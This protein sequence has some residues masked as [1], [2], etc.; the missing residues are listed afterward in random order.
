MKTKIYPYIF[1]LI[2]ATISTIIPLIF[3]E[4]SSLI[5][6]LVIFSVTGIV[7][8]FT[9]WLLLMSIKKSIE[10]VMTSI[11]KTDKDLIAYEPMNYIKS[12]FVCSL[13]GVG[14]LYKDKLVFSSHKLNFSH[15]ELVV[16]LSETQDIRSYR[17]LGI[18]NKGVEIVLKSGYSEKFVV[19]KTSVFYKNLTT[20]H[21]DMI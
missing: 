21:Q 5:S 3:E 7:T 11:D 6:C 18:F 13:G 19:D 14:C 2:V 20:V 10:N 15:K 16:F 4:R 17:I 8:F 12:C 9:M 1:A